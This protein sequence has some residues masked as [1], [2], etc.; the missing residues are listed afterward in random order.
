MTDSLEMV[1]S[2]GP[3]SQRMLDEDESVAE[4][5]GLGWFLAYLPCRIV[6]FPCWVCNS[7]VTV[8]E[9]EQMIKVFNGKYA[10]K[11][12]EA[13]LHFFD[14]FYY[15]QHR[16]NTK[17]V[18]HNMPTSKMVDRSGTPLLVSGMFNY[19][20]VDGYKAMYEVEDYRSFIITTAAAAI[21]ATVSK[22]N[23]EGNAHA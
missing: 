3:P 14:C 18:S 6:C 23:Y 20:I 10:G 1:D 8:N 17:V 21:K 13:G 12:N 16:F 4:E 11:I 7:I 2:T 5:P 9:N 15:Q 22:Y 19:Q